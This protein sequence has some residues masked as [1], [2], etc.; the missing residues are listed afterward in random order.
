MRS[1]RILVVDDEKKIVENI[2]FCLKREGF[3]TTPAYNGE[4]A[5]RIFESQRFDL[6]LL[7]VS[8]PDM[9]GYQVME[10]LFG[11]DDEVMVYHH[12]RARHR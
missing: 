2:S 9:N 5:I 3:T 7:D 11:L 12:H 6:V 1:E 10:H 4:E 8:M